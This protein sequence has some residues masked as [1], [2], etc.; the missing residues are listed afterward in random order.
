MPDGA[1]RDDDARGTAV[2]VV[3]PLSPGGRDDSAG[4]DD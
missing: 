1:P 3:E 4:R 2:V